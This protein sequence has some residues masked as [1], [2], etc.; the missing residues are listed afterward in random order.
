[1]IVHRKSPEEAFYPLMGQSVPFVPYRDAGYGAATYHITILDCLKG[2]HKALTD[3]LFDLQ[4]FDVDQYE[5]YERVE[6]GDFNFVTP[7]FL[8]LASP[9]EEVPQ[10]FQASS[11]NNRYGKFYSACHIDSLIKYLHENNIKVIIRLNNKTYDKKR[12]VDAGIE[13]IDLYF[14]DGTT[15]PE[16]IVKKFLEICETRKGKQKIFLIQFRMYCSSLQ[17]W[18]G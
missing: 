4:N 8:A 1:M 5:F 10:H 12:F 16:G 18:T 11:T 15:P 2:L 6:N 13:H 14:P 7:K 17:S 9:K 3:G